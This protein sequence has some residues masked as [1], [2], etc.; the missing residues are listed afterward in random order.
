MQI[1]WPELSKIVITAGLTIMGG[2]FLLVIGQLFEKFSIEPLRRYRE[3]VGEIAV[4]LIYFANIYLNPG[5][6]IHDRETLN[7]VSQNLRRLASELVA[8]TNSIHPY[9][10]FKW[11]H[12]I[13]SEE[14]VRLAAS[15]LIRLSNGLFRSG[16]REINV[17]EE[18]R[19]EII[20]LLSIRLID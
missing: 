3:T 5:A 19:Q 12:W 17:N 7:E 2:I 16:A 18:R 8:G 11:L 4:S 14:N 6:D 13:P 15:N 20:H 9:L 10:L 1:D